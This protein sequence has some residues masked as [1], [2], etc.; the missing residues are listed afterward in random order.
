M[1]TLLRAQGKRIEGETSGGRDE[2]S[3]WGATNGSQNRFKRFDFPRFDGEDP[4]NWIYKA[5]QYFSFNNTN[6]LQRILI[7]SYHM[8]G[9]AL[10][11]FQDFEES[12][13]MTSWE[14]FTHALRTRFGPTAYDD[15]MES[16][17]RLKQ[18][19]TV[20][21]YKAQFEA[22]SNRLRGLDES[23]KLSCFLSGLRDDIRYPVR[24]L[25]PNTLV[26]AFGL[27]KLQEEYVACGKRT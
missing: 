3:N 7:A 8:E 16:L 23:Y 6:P 12:R 15:P 10:T 5:N 4:N 19:S 14:A 22:L 27:A 24:L 9:D 25:R 13:G 17:T 11:W 26:M 21:A 20:T 2:T 1:E 18:T